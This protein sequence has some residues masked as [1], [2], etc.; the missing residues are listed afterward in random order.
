MINGISK[1]SIWHFG[2]V[3]PSSQP[4]SRREKDFTSLS[5]RERESVA[6]VREQD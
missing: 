1:N 6:R 3:V 4:F 2:K 5:R